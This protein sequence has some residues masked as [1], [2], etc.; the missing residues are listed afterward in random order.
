[1]DVGTI[2]SISAFLERYEQDVEKGRIVT[3]PLLILCPLSLGF[4]KRDEVPGP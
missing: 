2:V 1:M 3:D 4:A